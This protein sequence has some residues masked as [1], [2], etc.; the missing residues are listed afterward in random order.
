MRKLKLRIQKLE[1][2]NTTM[3][4]TNGHTLELHDKTMRRFA[5]SFLKNGLPFSAMIF[6]ID[7]DL[8][9]LRWLCIEIFC[10]LSIFIKSFEE[11]A[12]FLSVLNAI[13]IIFLT[14]AGIFQ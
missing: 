2:I 14:E 10:Q 4:D 7:N 3:F 12:L 9:R 6:T 13:I 5:C 1:L 8:T 11:G